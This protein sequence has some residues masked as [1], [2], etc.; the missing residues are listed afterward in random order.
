[1]FIP[2]RALMGAA[3]LLASPLPLRAQAGFPTRPVRAVL[4]F[5]PGGAIDAVTRLIAPRVGE[6]LGQPLV[7]ENRGGAVGSL[8]AG[9]VASAPADGHTLLFDASQ[10][11]AA[12]F[13]LSNLA[14]SYDTAF[15]PVTQLTSV[16]LLLAA[17]PSLPAQTIVEF[18]ALGR[19]RAAAGRPL[20]Y[21]SGGN[22]AST[23][24]A[25][26]LFQKLAGFEVTHVPFRGGGPA[27]QGLLA[28]TVDFHIGTVGSTAA[29]VRDGRLRGLAVSTAARLP[30]FPDLP[31]LQEAGLAGYDWNEWGGVFAPAGT[32][33]PIL[34]RL[35]A[36]LREALFQPVVLER[37]GA[38]GMVPVGSM[39]AEFAAFV[40]AQKALTG[41]LTRDAGI[42]VN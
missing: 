39:P 33:G 26:A 42:M 25:G 30:A 1:M 13:L 3:P 16:P 27:V 24:Y 22:G 31:T 15:A 5:P 23:H 7:V 28:G 11:A 35:Q 17:H 18:L 9:N 38:I 10:H 6:L 40:A 37:L 4:S 29:L 8:A 19:A 21:A 41:S 32:P 12:P 2:R 14:F 34:A 20:T 36:V